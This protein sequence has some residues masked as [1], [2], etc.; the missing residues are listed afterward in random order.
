MAANR[1]DLM[2]TAEAAEWLGYS[3]EYL[4]DMARRRRVPAI[5]VGP[6]RWRF[7]REVLQEWIAQGCPPAS[8]QPT[9]FQGQE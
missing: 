9:L 3:E 5:K 6:R 7:Y 2:T 8:E 4:R 1:P